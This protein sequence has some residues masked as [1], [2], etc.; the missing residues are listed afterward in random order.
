M[1][2]WQDATRN[3]HH[4]HNHH[5]RRRRRRGSSLENM[6]HRTGARKEDIPLSMER[7]VAKKRKWK[8]K[9]EHASPVI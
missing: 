8:K 5:Y 4:H 7:S 1:L 9:R 2:R 6:I 3:M